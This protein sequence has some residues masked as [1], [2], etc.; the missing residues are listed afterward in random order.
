MGMV[1]SFNLRVYGL[2]VHNNR[3]LVTD[4]N[5][6]GMIMTKFPGGGLEKGEGIKSCLIREFQ[7]ELKIEISVGTHFY[8][9]DFFQ[10]SAFDETDQLI[11]FYYFVSTEELEKIPSPIPKD[12]LFKNAQGFRWVD[13]DKIAASAFTFPI[14][15]VVAE[16]LFQK[17]F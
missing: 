14:D 5:R 17:A 13:L 15:R 12:T 2:L 7:E 8:V 9:N 11:S 3:V 4:E 1:K 10:A 6:A 16:K